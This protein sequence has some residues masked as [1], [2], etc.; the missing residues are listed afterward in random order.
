MATYIGIVNNVLYKQT[1][2]YHGHFYSSV[3]FPNI[4]QIFLVKGYF[5]RKGIIT[6]SQIQGG[7]LQYNS[8]QRGSER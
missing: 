4:M 6:V 2:I 5:T 8:V 3:M 7:F 1:L